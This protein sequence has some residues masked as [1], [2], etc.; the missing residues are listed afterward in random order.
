MIQ[1][2]YVPR[3]APYCSLP[4][5]QQNLFDLFSLSS[6]RGDFVSHQKYF[7]A[8][9][10]N[11]V[12]V[13]WA[14]RYVDSLSTP[15]LPHT[16]FF[17]KFQLFFQ[18]SPNSTKPFLCGDEKSHFW[19]FLKNHIERYKFIKTTTETFTNLFQIS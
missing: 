15:T 11:K 19:G 10:Q 8:S 18:L 6:D 1:R 9:S 14:T 7:K 17:E 3:F 16:G 4:S 5:F 2:Q 13:R 12:A